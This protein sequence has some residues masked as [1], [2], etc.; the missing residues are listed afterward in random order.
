MFVSLAVAFWCLHTHY[1]GVFFVS[2]KR[3]VIVCLFVCLK[4]IAVLPRTVF[5][6][7][8]Q[9]RDDAMARIAEVG[10]GYGIGCFM[11]TTAMASGVR[12]NP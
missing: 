6:R 12:V 8:L 4:I 1:L 11:L 2:F 9:H 3:G 7:G 10:W 5:G